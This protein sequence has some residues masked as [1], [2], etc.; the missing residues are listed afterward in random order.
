MPFVARTIDDTEDIYLVYLSLA[1]WAK[2]LTTAFKFED[3]LSNEFML[4]QQLLD[5]EKTLA[6]YLSQRNAIKDALKVLTQ[7]ETAEVNARDALRSERCT[8]LKG[9]SDTAIN[10][11]EL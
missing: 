4:G 7:L 10:L 11:I 6:Q 1:T 5:K 3:L 2:K 9:F 8:I